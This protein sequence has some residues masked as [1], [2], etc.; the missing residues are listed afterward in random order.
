MRSGLEARI[1]ELFGYAHAVLFGMARSGVS[2]LL[3]ALDFRHRPFVIPSNLCPNLLLTLHAGGAKAVLA[4]ADDTCGLP[5]DSAFVEAMRNGDEVGIVMPTHLYGFVRD[6]SMTLRE[7]RSRGWFVL[8]NDTI[9]TRARLPGECRK[10][11]GDALVVSFGY[12][13][14]IEAGGGGAMLTD[15]ALLA[16]ELR[17]IGKTFP[18]LDDRAIQT[19]NEF[20]IFV[21]KMRGSGQLENALLEKAPPCRFSFPQFLEEPLARALEGFN[22]EVEDRFGRM[23][24]WEQALAP[25]SDSLLPAGVECA[26]PWRLIK[27]VPR[28]RDEIVNALRAEGIDAGTNFPSL[29]A[30]FPTLLAGQEG[31]GAKRWENEVLNLWLTPRYDRRLIRQAADAIGRIVSRSDR[32]MS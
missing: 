6:Y 27:R 2:A 10:S 22:G 13:K 3:D 24:I 4:D 26:V 21:R 28:F 23:E 18:P 20:M 5:S 1:A 11:S 19:E 29:F 31:E 15:D 7:A 9:A 12:A 32:V 8:E 30:S 14:G 17:S 16:R 25:Y